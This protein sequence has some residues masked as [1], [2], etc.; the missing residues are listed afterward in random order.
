[1]KHKLEIKFSAGPGFA[2]SI[3]AKASPRSTQSTRS[4]LVILPDGKVVRRVQPNGENAV[5]PA[6]NAPVT[7]QKVSP[8]P[9]PRNEMPRR[10]FLSLRHAQVLA[11]RLSSRN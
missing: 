10:S 7:T 2:P 6:A 9:R 1:M 3:S 11:A 5:R 8:A 4:I